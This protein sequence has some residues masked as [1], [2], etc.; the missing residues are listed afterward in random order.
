MKFV[1]LSFLILLLF[2]PV[3]AQE[4]FGTITGVV[5]DLD[6]TPISEAT[7]YTVDYTNLRRR[8]HTTTDENGHFVLRNVPAGTVSIH[9]YKESA[10]YA[11]TFFSFFTITKK[12]W[13]TVQVEGERTTDGVALELAKYA[14]LKLSIQN[15]QGEAVGATLI[16]TRVD[17]P[18]QPYSVG[19]DLSGSTVMLVPPVPFRLQIRADGYEVW[20]YEA[21]AGSKRSNVLKPQAGETFEWLVRLRR[22]H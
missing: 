22:A 6:G 13:Q 20:Q 3:S 14:T 8:V 5:H 18:K 4:G 12:A 1:C 16:F 21:D 17:N 7:V 11:D 15:E 9:A 10:G 2:R 19:S